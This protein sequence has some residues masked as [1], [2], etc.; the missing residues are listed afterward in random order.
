MHS[1]IVEFKWEPGAR[2]PRSP[3]AGS[4]GGRPMNKEPIQ[5]VPITKNKIVKWKQL[6]KDAN[7]QPE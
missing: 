5:Y 1:W 3:A 2:L 6:A 7:I 4:P